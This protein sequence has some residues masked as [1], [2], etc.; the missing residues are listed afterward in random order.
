MWE[1]KAGRRAS[2]SLGRCPPLRVYAEKKSLTVNKQKSEMKIYPSP[3]W[4]CSIPLY[5]HFQIPWCVTGKWCR[6]CSWR[7][8]LSQPAFSKKRNLSRKITI[9]TGCMLTCGSLKLLQFLLGYSQ[10]RFG[11]HHIYT[12]AQRWTAPY[13]IQCQIVS[14]GS[15][16]KIPHG[17]CGSELLQFNWFSAAM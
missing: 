15:D 17:A 14:W 2:C 8:A 7:H 13:C 3:S 6:C 12:R 5:G 16:T 9:P 10:A 11:L 4:L 1:T